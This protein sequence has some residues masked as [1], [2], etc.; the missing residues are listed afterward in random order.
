M[1]RWGPSYV[2]WHK[3][4]AVSN[5][6]PSARREIGQAFRATLRV[7]L[8]TPLRAT[9]PNLDYVPEVTGH[10]DQRRASRR[11]ARPSAR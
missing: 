7:I 10:D 6:A 8:C 9:A 11:A 4:S 2:A 3:D 1:L 5:S